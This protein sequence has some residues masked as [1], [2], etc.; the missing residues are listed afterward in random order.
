M[1]DITPKQARARL[2]QKPDAWNE[3]TANPTNPD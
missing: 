2:E 1:T 3:T